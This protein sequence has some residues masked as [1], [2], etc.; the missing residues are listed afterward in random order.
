M[1]QQYNSDDALLTFDYGA[2]LIAGI[3]RMQEALAEVESLREA[4]NDSRVLVCSKSS[5]ECFI[6]LKMPPP[7]TKANKKGTRRERGPNFTTQELLS[8]AQ[9]VRE[10]LPQDMDDWELVAQLHSAKFPNNHR[11]AK[12]LKLQFTVMHRK[13]QPTG[14]PAMP[15]HIRIAKEAHYE[16]G[17]EANLTDGNSGFEVLTLDP[18]SDVPTLGLGQPSQEANDNEASGG[19]LHGGNESDVTD[20]DIE[21]GLPYGGARARTV[22]RTTQEQETLNQERTSTAPG[23]QTTVITRRTRSPTPR[24]RATNSSTVESMVSMMMMDMRQRQM[25]HQERMTMERER[26]M[27]T[28]NDQTQSRLLMAQAIDSFA[29]AICGAYTSG[30]NNSENN[31]SEEY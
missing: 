6:N 10:V 5:A 20:S 4:A 2:M 22:P 18:P 3:L 28:R 27:E 24:G 25:E 9:T 19:E 14:D 23:S 1:M 29:K 26:A 31:N 17:A 13:K 7:T 8:L 12:S 11:K 15:D 16:I 30:T 21:G